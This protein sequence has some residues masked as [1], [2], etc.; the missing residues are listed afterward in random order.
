MSMGYFQT[1]GHPAKA[2]HRQFAQALAGCWLQSFVSVLLLE[3]L[4]ITNVAMVITDFG[5][6][7]PTCH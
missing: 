6:I 3:E 1:Q 2:S 4:L 7:I 5:F